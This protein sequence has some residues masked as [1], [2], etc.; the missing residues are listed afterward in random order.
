MSGGRGGCKTNNQH[1]F[2]HS[3]SE[4]FVL[5]QDI[6]NQRLVVRMIWHSLH[7][8]QSESVWSVLLS[9]IHLVPE[10]GWWTLTTP[11]PQANQRSVLCVSGQSEATRHWPCL[12]PWGLDWSHENIQ[13]TVRTQASSHSPLGSEKQ[14]AFQLFSLNINEP[15]R[16][17]LRLP[18]TM[19]VTAGGI[20]A[21]K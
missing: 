7:W 12:A 3:L 16:A 1:E 21:I 20:N 5:V 15:S 18:K 13:V 17:C 19:F 2:I 11:R 8:D 10:W 6:N 4:R 14:S 9:A